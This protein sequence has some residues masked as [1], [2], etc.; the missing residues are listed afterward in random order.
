[1]HDA[2][3][4][5]ALP[6]PDRPRLG[7]RD[8]AGALGIFCIVVLATFPV[9]LPFVL[10]TDMANALLVSRVLSLAMLFAGG[11]ALGRYAG[12]G[13]LKAG[14]TLVG[15]GMFLTAAIIALGG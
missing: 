10:M 5:G 9:A 1:V 8:Y 15:V 2:P 14:F 12:Y 11:M 7:R 6:V 3:G 4:G 13:G